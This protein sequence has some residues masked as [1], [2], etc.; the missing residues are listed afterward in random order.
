MVEEKETYKCAKCGCPISKD[1]YETDQ[2]F[3]YECREFVDRDPYD[4]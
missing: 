2:S 4:D 3:C 1:E